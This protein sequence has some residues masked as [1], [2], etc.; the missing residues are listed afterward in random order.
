ME[1]KEVFNTT[2]EAIEA[3]SYNILVPI[4]LGNKFFTKNLEATDNIRKYVKWALEH[5]KEKVLI[6][7]VDKIQHTNYFVRGTRVTELHSRKRVLEDG[8]KVESSIQ[9]MLSKEFSVDEIRKITLT[10]YE[11][12]EKND[13]YCREVTH[14]IYR[15]FKNNK[16]FSQGVL[17]SVRSS[18]KDREFSEED[19]WRLCDYVLDEFALAYVGVEYLGEYYGIYIYPHTDSVL[20]FIESIKKGDTFTD[21]SKKLPERK[22]SVAILN[23]S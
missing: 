10:R 12:Y 9:E 21:L 18:I 1:V 15:E 4:C 11:E 16:E 6:L 7:V 19:V 20:L 8:K 14:E 23:E 13:P 5:T 22:M 3:K 2:R 17:Q